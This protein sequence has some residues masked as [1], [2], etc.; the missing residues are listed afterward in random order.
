M[1]AGSIGSQ[2]PKSLVA[3]CMKTRDATQ[4]SD[5]EAGKRCGA[6]SAGPSDPDLPSKPRGPQ[7]HATRSHQRVDAKI[8]TSQ[9]CRSKAYMVPR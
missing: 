1:R 5:G 7:Y 9:A 3:R 4:S 8:L 6:A 2:P